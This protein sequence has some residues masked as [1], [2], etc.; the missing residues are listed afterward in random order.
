MLGLGEPYHHAL[1]PEIKAF[2]V[3]FEG[4]DKSFVDDALV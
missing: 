3:E 1:D 2:D 4:I